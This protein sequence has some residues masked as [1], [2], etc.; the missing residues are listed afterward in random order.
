[1]TEF[2]MND[3]MI[4]T[5]NNRIYEAETDHISPKNSLFQ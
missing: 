3:F 1:M 5:E 4:L 2:F